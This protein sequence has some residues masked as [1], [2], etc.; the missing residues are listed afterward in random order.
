LD[1]CCCD[2]RQGATKRFDERC[3]VGADLVGDGYDEL[4]WKN[5]LLAKRAV[6]IDAD[7]VVSL[8]YIVVESTFATL[9]A[10]SAKQGWVHND[11][12]SGLNVG[13]PV[14]SAF[15][16]PDSFMS[17]DDTGSRVEFTD[18]DASIG[19]TDAA[20]QNAND[21]IIRACGFGRLHSDQVQRA[22]I[23]SE[24]QG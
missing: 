13:H 22:R 20:L 17:H 23:V 14:A 21:D 7:F 6:P 18:E 11:A 8:V 5:N 1:S 12:I 2:V 24:S 3:T 19:S 16:D 4:R 9:E 15:D 10:F